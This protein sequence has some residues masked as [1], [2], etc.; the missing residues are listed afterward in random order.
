M[1]YGHSYFASICSKSNIEKYNIFISGNPS[2]L[3][4]PRQFC[5]PDRYPHSVTDDEDPIEDNQYSED[6]YPSEMPSTF[7]S[8]AGRIMFVPS[9]D[10]NETYIEDQ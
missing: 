9:F 5:E 7:P 3:R 6:E 10:L 1:R 2:T 8:P 4:S